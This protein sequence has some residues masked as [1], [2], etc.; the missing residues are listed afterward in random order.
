MSA[1][2]QTSSKQRS[3]V[4]LSALMRKAEPMGDRR[5]KRQNRKAW[6]KDE[7]NAY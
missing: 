3:F 4:A 1:K 6:K 7:R 2:K 5:M